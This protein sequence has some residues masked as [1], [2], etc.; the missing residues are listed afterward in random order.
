MVSRASRQ[1][2]ANRFSLMGV[3]SR[4]GGVGERGSAGRR[5]SGREAS[6]GESLKCNGL[7]RQ[8]Q[9]EHSGASGAGPGPRV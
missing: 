7:I 6:M 2:R 9:L 5:A 3:D 4:L 8:E 1:T